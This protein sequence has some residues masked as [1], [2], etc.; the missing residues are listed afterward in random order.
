MWNRVAGS[1]KELTGKVK[2]QWGDLT[3]D[4]LTVIAGQRDQLMGK[5]QERYGCARDKAEAEIRDFEKRIM[6][7][8]RRFD[9]G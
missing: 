9:A 3:D 6:A 2:E 8:P 4:D 5:I 7:E 1:W